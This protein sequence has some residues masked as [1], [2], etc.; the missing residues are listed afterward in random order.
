MR[1]QPRQASGPKG[2]LT[3]LTAFA[4]SIAASVA[5]CYFSWHEWTRLETQQGYGSVSASSSFSC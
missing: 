3:D 4:R 2:D 1:V 5:G